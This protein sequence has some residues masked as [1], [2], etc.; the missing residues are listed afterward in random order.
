VNCR[1]RGASGNQDQSPPARPSPSSSLVSSR[2]GFDIQ[3]RLGMLR[4]SDSP[5]SRVRDIRTRQRTRIISRAQQS[6]PGAVTNSCNCS[7]AIPP[8]HCM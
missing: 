2:L 4:I 5:S 7:L 1:T 3:P 6:P 8:Q